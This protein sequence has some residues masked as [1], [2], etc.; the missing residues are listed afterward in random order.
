MVSP[1]AAAYTNPYDCLTTWVPLFRG[2]FLGRPAPPSLPFSNVILRCSKVV[3]LNVPPGT[4]LRN[5][6]KHAG[7]LRNLPPEPSSGTFLRNLPPE[8][9]SGTYSCDPHR[10][11]PELIWAEDLISLRCW[12][13]NTTEKNVKLDQNKC[14][15][16][17]HKKYSQNT[18]EMYTNQTHVKAC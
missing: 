13:K 12:G 8:P 14:P 5:L 9:S 4:C 10:H 2:E 18:K 7:I 3:L 15:T 16:I 6:D 11:T 17:T 1:T